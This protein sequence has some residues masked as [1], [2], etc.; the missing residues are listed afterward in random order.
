MNLVPV[1]RRQFKTWSM[2]ILIAIGVINLAGI[3][4]NA[5]NAVDIFSP[6]VFLVVNSVLAFLGGVA[7]LI[8]QHIEV[9]PEE[10]EELITAAVTLPVKE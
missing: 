9:T 7:K 3:L 10:K 8:Q 6:K 4:A 1:P 2:W 5:L